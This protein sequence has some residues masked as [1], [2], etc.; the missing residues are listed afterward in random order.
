MV[1]RK[2]SDRTRRAASR[3]KPCCNELLLGAADGAYACDNELE[4]VLDY[5]ER[6]A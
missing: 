6:T 5:L 1:R 3:G 2:I 4:C